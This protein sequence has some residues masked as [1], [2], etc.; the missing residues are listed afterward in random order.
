MI[1]SDSGVS[2]WFREDGP[3]GRDRAAERQTALSGPGHN[4]G[5]IR[6][7]MH[8]AWTALLL[9]HKSPNLLPRRAL[10]AGRLDATKK[11]LIL[12]LTLILA[13]DRVRCGAGRKKSG[14][15]Q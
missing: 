10:P 13:V 3:V 15:G 14:G 7:A 9:G 8:P 2:S 5:S 6:P 1:S 12:A 4:Y 11:Q